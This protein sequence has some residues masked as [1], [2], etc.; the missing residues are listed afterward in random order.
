[1]SALAPGATIGILGGGQLGRMLAIAAAEL[2]FSVHVYC[3][4][5][6][7]PAFDVAPSSTCAPYDDLDAV[8]TFAA[9]CDVVTYE[10]ENVPVATARAAA[11]AAP[12]RPGVKALEVSQDRFTEKTFANE[13]GVETAYFA[14]IDA[15]ADLP[16]AIKK[17]R[18]P[19]I[20]KTRREGYDGK[21]QI[22][23]GKDDIDKPGWENAAFDAVGGAPSVLEAVV[24][25]KRELSVLAVRGL[26]GARV[27]YDLTENR[28]ESGVLAESKAP[29][30]AAPEVEARAVDIATALLRAL[31]YVGVLAVELF[32]A[33]NG[34][35]L[36]NE[37][38]PRV[39]NSGHWTMDAC[40]AS[41]FE[42]HIRAVAG[43]PLGD[44]T[45]A[46]DAVMTNL[47]GDE[48]LAAPELAKDPRA[49]VHV[50]GKRELKPGRKTGHVTRLSK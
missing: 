20:L 22:R 32:E 5:A 21:G 29:A 17:V 1:M 23:L 27:F 43:W 2:G 49:C 44:A 7:S 38:A 3:P 26:D 33:D 6:D 41:Q 48:V 45:R 46:C 50:Y 16:A 42:N 8:R 36:M 25:F 18:A 28:H 14:K 40:P 24:E 9:S 30:G 37:I 47:F 34:R 19:A 31:D 15:A 10:F 12:L 39:H 35:L 4:D 13:L 11:E